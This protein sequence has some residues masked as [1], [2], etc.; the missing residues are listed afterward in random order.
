MRS[1]DS[2]L[3]RK[4]VFGTKTFNRKAAHERD[5]DE[6]ETGA[7]LRILQQVKEANPPVFKENAYGCCPCTKKK[8]ADTAVGSDLVDWLVANHPALCQDSDLNDQR[9]GATVV[10][11]RMLFCRLVEHVSDEH[12]FQDTGFFYTCTPFAND[13]LHDDAFR[14]VLRHADGN[15]HTHALEAN[16]A[17]AVDAADEVELQ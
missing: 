10:G 14:S 2:S 11:N 17:A 13:N 7:L 3:G 15:L 8:Y 5:A 12:D 6:E 9:S 4:L 1:R 16:P